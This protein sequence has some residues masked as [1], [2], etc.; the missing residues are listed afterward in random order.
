MT[1]SDTRVRLILDAGGE[2]WL[3]MTP[4]QL[5][6]ELIRLSRDVRQGTDP[7]APATLAALQQ[8]IRNTLP[9]DTAEDPTLD[10]RGRKR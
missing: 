2:A 9:S 10:A 3:D 7:T 8:F 5:L 6:G 1:H 4:R